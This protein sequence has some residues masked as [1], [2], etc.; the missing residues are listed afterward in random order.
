[1]RGEYLGATPF[2]LRTIGTTSACAEN[3]CQ[4]GYEA[5]WFRNYL[6]VRGEYPHSSQP[7]S[8]RT[9]LPPRARRIP[10]ATSGHPLTSGTTS[11]CAENTLE[12]IKGFMLTW[13]Y[14]RVR[15]EYAWAE[16]GVGIILELPP[17][18]RRIRWESSWPRLKNGTTSAC[19]ENTLN[20]LG[21]L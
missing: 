3:T 2:P 9:E 7:S 11:A 8:S 17:R 14:L 21:L 12:V 6:R 5:G 16:I 20:E 18:A 1:M 15:G 13:N 10:G 4:G 19:A